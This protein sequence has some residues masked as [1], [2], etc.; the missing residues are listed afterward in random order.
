[1]PQL[2]NITIE[3]GWNGFRLKDLQKSSGSCCG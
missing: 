3:Y 1:L 2:E